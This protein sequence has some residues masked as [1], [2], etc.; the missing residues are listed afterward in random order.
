MDAVNNFLIM[1]NQYIGNKSSWFPFVLLGVG[2][3]FTLYLKFPQI[4][5]FK[6]AI[7]IVS[8]KYEKESFTGDT[9]HFQSLATALSGTVGTGNIGGVGLALER[10]NPAL[11]AA[12]QVRG[13]L[14]SK[15]NGAFVSIL[16][17]AAT[18]AIPSASARARR[19]A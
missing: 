3:F 6:H 11:V 7:R 1:I 17:P 18:R 9:T 4:R 2:V 14:K 15:Q 16:A 19:R 13:G 12:Y 8:G 5:F 10:H